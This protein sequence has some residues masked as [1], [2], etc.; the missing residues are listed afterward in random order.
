MADVVASMLALLL[1]VAGLVVPALRRVRVTVHF[2]HLA[3]SETPLAFVNV[4]NRS[5]GR[6]VELG[7]IWFELNSQVA[8]LNPQRPLPRVLVPGQSWEAWIAIS[9]VGGVPR[10]KLFRA[11][12]A[13]LSG[14]KVIGSKR[15]TNVPP[16]GDVPGWAA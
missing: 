10:H 12:R 13:R 3:G 1:D 6:E 9:E 11:A 8:V 4:A 16:A 5:F 14:G 15:N 2:G 7:A